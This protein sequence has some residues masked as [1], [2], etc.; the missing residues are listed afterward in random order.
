M[1]IT[2]LLTEKQIWQIVRL[3]K[4][5]DERF[6]LMEKEHANLFYDGYSGYRK[7]HSYTH[8]I[9][10]AFRKE[11][12]IDGFIIEEISYGLNDGMRQPELHNDKIILHVYNSDCGFS[13][14]VFKRNCKKYNCNINQF[15]IYGCIVFSKNK[16]GNL[17]S[18]K[19][20][21]PNYNGDFIHQ[22][23]LYN[24]VIKMKTA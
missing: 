18:I 4:C 19:V 20:S 7:S 2:D 8:A 6:S 1:D 15:P 23:V 5:N 16:N 24:N 21:I 12:I 10:S 17:K 14:Q 22:F 3:I 13:S 11:T 9:I